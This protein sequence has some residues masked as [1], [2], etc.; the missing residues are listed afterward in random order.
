MRL[1]LLWAMEPDALKAYLER[2]GEI[3]ENKI[4]QIAAGDGR[5]QKVSNVWSMNEDQTEATINIQGVL[6]PD[7]PDIFDWFFG[8]VVTGY[9]QI[10][11]AI[12]QI[13]A[14]D[15]IKTVTLAMNTPGGTV[16]GVDETFLSLSELAKVKTLIA[17]NEGMIA[18]GGY[19]LAIAADRIEAISPSAETGSIGVI[20][21]GYDFSKALEDRGIK[22]V[23]IVSKNAPEKD[24]RISTEEGQARILQRINAIERVF[25]DRVAAG[26]GISLE[27]VLKDFG[28]GGVLIAQDPDPDKSDAISVGMIDGLVGMKNNSETNNLNSKSKTLKTEV[29]TMDLQTFLDQNP[30]AK[31]EIETMRKQASDEG[32]KAEQEAVK[33]RIT[34]AKPFLNS[35]YG[36]AVH[37]LAVEVITGDADPSAL[38]ATVTAIDHQKEK[39]ASNEA[40]KATDATK[41][42]PPEPPDLSKGADDKPEVADSAEDVDAAVDSTRKKLGKDEDKTK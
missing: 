38:K 37:K 4:P 11:G 19:W 34:V 3:P 27:T 12:K 16:D 42:T 13:M 10:R 25:T 36:E 9:Q 35:E 41:D 18:S 2:T 31:S 22:Q 20:V 6:T 30:V 24:S 28:R 40:A 26:R 32:A 5:Y 21:A 17:R 39:A 23:V 29:Q 33:A 14:I 8:F 1:D 15:S 7:G